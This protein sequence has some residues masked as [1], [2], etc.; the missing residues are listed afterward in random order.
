MGAGG[1]E[2]G[3]TRREHRIGRYR[4]GG[5]WR[6][7]SPRGRRISGGLDRQSPGA[8]DLDT[9]RAV[10]ETNFF[11]VIMVTEAMLPLLRRS[12]AARIVNVSSGVGS[13]H[14]MTDPGHYMSR[15]PAALAY[16]TSKTA[17][18]SLTVQYAKALA[19]DRILV[20]AV[21]PGPCATDFT[22]GLPYPVT[23]TAADGAEIAVRLATIDPDGPSGGFFDD[24]GR[25]PW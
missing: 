6:R 1:D 2:A 10:F 15:L 23:R 3:L 25:V 24:G 4:R 18:N 11:G 19:A 5:G 17:L 22:K 9:V 8:A 12:T 14:N 16:P 7:R 21:A 20:N 13:L